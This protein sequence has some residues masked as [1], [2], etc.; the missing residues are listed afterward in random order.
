M[1]GGTDANRKGLALEVRRC[2]DR[3]RTAEAVL[4][5]AYEQIVASGRRP[6]SGWP[7]PQPDFGQEAARQQ[8][9]QCAGG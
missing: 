5:F 3:S 7:R 8:Q 9:A 4:A 2:Y 6:G 1:D